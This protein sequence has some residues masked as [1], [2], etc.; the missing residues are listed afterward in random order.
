MRISDWSSD[1]CSSDLLDY[2]VVNSFNTSIGSPDSPERFDAGG[3]ATG[4]TVVNL[5]LNR[6]LNVDFMKNLG[7]AV[8]GEYRNENFKIRPGQEA[9]YINGPYSAYGAPGGS[10]VLPGFR[11]NNAVDVTRDRFAGYVEVDGDVSVEL[12]FPLAG[13]Y[14]HYSDFG[15]TLNGKAPARRPAGR[16]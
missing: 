16:R 10:Q 15:D 3:M 11:T 13:R 9:S 8:G 5:D 6:P 7:V 14:D 2:G 1:V 4:Q 12:S